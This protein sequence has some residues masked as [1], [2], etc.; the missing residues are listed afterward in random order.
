MK[1]Y[2]YFVD[3]SSVTIKNNQASFKS[4]RVVTPEHVI[5]DEREFLGLLDP[6]HLRLCQVFPCS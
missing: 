1:R 3:D 2:D 4:Q 6:N 5:D